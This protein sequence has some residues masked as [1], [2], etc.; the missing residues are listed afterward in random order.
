[1]NSDGEDRAAGEQSAHFVRTPLHQLRCCLELLVMGEA[2]HLTREGR[3]CL[4]GMVVALDQLEAALLDC[5]R[6][7]AP[8]SLA[9]AAVAL[10]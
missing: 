7:A 6:N 3:D 10:D 8:Q 1:M 4:A 5:S 9:R 2:G